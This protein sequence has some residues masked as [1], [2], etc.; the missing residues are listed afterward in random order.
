[1]TT[2]LGG[3]GRQ[4][5][6][7]NA[8]TSR[9]AASTSA[10]PSRRSRRVSPNALVDSSSAA[11]AGPSDMPRSRS[12]QNRDSRWWHRRHS[13]PMTHP[14]PGRDVGEH[15]VPESDVEVGTHQLCDCIGRRWPN[16]AKVPFRAEPAG[17][18]LRH[19]LS[20]AIRRAASASSPIRE[21][22]LRLVEEEL[23]SD[24]WREGR[25]CTCDGQRFSGERA[26]RRWRHALAFVALQLLIVNVALAWIYPEHR[27]IALRAVRTLD[28]ERK[29]QF[30]ALW[31]QARTGSR[32]AAVC[33]RRRHRA[34]R[35]AGLHRLGSAQCDRRRPFLLEQGHAR[36]RPRI[37]LDPGGR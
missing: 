27:E 33:G 1:M 8:T 13:R 17:P 11:G 35:G 2:L 34:G 25:G 7:I 10:M 18:M 24:V 14:V 20:V 36:H 6:A 23:A 32:A 31:A 28:A 22:Q 15:L 37:E 29:V 5:A 9:T 4:N 30:D 19:A 3:P 26:R 21:A 12:S 16:G